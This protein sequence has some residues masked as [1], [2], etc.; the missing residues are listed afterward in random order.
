MI[1]SALGINV[2]GHRF[3]DT[4]AQSRQEILKDKPIL[5]YLANLEL[6]SSFAFFSSYFNLFPI[7]CVF[8]F[9]LRFFG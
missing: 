7:L 2:L 8:V 6:F 9:F 5:L 3:C 1:Y 4:E